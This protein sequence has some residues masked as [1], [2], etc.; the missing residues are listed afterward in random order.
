MFITRDVVKI[1]GIAFLWASRLFY[2]TYAFLSALIWAISPNSLITSQ[3]KTLANLNL[4]EACEDRHITS[5]TLKNN[6]IKRKPKLY[7]KTPNFNNEIMKK[8][9]SSLK[10]LEKLLESVMLLKNVHK[11]YFTHFYIVGFISSFTILFWVLVEINAIN[12]PLI[13][14]K[15]T[16]FNVSNYCYRY[17]EIKSNAASINITPI[18]ISLVMMLIQ[19]TRRLYECLFITN[20]TQHSKMLLL[21][22]LVGIIYYVLT[23]MSFFIEDLFGDYNINSYNKTLNLPTNK[24]F[25][26]GPIEH[27]LTFVYVTVFFIASFFQHLT[28]RSLA[29]LRNGK[30]KPISSIKDIY[31]LPKGA[32]FKYV[33]CPAYLCEIIIYVS[34]ALTCA[35]KN[36]YIPWLNVISVFLGLTLSAKKQYSW[37]LE[38]Y[39]GETR[40]NWKAIVP[41][42]Y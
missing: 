23:P 24:K 37:F 29:N 9:Q 2:I 31:P 19:V 17:T 40:E 22:Y 8:S 25:R 33:A 16:F 4:D 20:T 1:G 34:L 13:C 15:N 27:R 18:L 5:V 6:L 10:C 30:K 28:H 39:P 14:D 38:Y 3:G 21:Q 7:N 36:K 35:N 26:L 11:K 41:F 32:L 12:I 42:L